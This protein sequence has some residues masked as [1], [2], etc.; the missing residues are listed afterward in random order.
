MGA[1]PAKTFPMPTPYGTSPNIGVVSQ[2]QAAQPA[3]QQ[4]FLPLT[5]AS[6]AQQPAPTNSQTQQGS[7]GILGNQGMNRLRNTNTFGG[8]GG[9]T[10]F[11]G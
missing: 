4:N 2:A 8:Y 5:G 6:Q 10:P 9:P 7:L 1:T 11:Y 3:P